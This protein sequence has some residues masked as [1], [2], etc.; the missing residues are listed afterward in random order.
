MK[1]SFWEGIFAY[2]KGANCTSL[3]NVHK[4][5]TQSILLLS[6]TEDDGHHIRKTKCIRIFH[7]TC[8]EDHYDCTTLILQTYCINSHYFNASSIELLPLKMFSRIFFSIAQ[9]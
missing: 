9:L 7:K 4:Y 1:N 2:V 8:L 6:S 5:F 3:E